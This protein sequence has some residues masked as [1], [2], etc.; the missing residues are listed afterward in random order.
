MDQNW[1]VGQRFNGP[2]G[3][4]LNRVLTRFDQRWV[5]LSD[6]TSGLAKCLNL[7]KGCFG[8]AS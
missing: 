7:T 8:A 5:N 3:D 1:L 2:V 6:R 4:C